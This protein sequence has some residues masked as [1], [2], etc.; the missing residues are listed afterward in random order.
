MSNGQMRFDESQ[1]QRLLE[2][3]TPKASRHLTIE[4]ILTFFQVI[5]IVCG[6]IWTILSYME[7]EKDQRRMA[8]E[9]QGLQL[10]QQQ[11]T[12]DLEIERGKVTLS[13][14]KYENDLKALEVAHAHANRIRAERKLT[15]TKEKQL[16]N[17]FALYTVHI[18]FTITN[19]SQQKLEVTSTVLEPYL[20]TR[21]QFSRDQSSL[22][23]INSPVELYED[24]EVDD[25]AEDAYIRWQPM[26]YRAGIYRSSD[27]FKQIKTGDSYTGL[28][29]HVDY[30]FKGGELATG[31]LEE[32]ESF[33]FDQDYSVIAKEGQLVGFVISL[34]LNRYKTMDDFHQFVDWATFREAES[35]Q[36]KK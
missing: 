25:V 4:R 11:L 3:V 9:S 30:D 17:T 22:H 29:R 15:I 6:G 32:N 14:Q 1:F 8:L 21:K 20:G 26:E 36:K 23:R 18:T 19:T 31:V 24:K 12:T 34:T 2:L 10:R 13:T 5:A 35:N 16:N 33:D 7:F 27:P 28:Q